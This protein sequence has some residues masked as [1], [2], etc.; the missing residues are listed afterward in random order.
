MLLEVAKT[1]IKYM[2]LNLNQNATFQNLSY[3]NDNVPKLS[4][5]GFS[6]W[7]CL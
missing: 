5:Q 3:G 6:L 2:L 4:F 1:G 7:R